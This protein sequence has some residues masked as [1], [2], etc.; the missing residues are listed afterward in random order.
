MLHV[1]S[2]GSLNS[3]DRLISNSSGQGKYLA[4][5]PM[6]PTNPRPPARPL[7]PAAAAQPGPP[8]IVPRA[9]T[10]HPAPTPPPPQRAPSSH[11]AT[12]GHTMPT[13]TNPPPTRHATMAPRG[14]TTGGNSRC[15]QNAASSSTGPHAGRAGL[16]DR[17]PMGPKGHRGPGTRAAVLLPP[18]Q[19]TQPSGG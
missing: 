16:H 5:W 2:D 17:H 14:G 12:P 8:G 3:P 9:H 15:G 7:R 4:V 11:R 13:C 1:R 19:P 18:S 10:P 6:P